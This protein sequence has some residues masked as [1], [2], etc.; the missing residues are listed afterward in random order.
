PDPQKWPT[1]HGALPDNGSAEALRAALCQETL[2]FVRAGLAARGCLICCL[3]GRSRSVSVLLGFLLLERGVGV[4]EG[5]DLVRSSRP[6]EDTPDPAPTRA[7]STIASSTPRRR[8][9]GDVG[10]VLCLRRLQREAAGALPAPAAAAGAGSSPRAGR[11]AVA[12]TP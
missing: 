7:Q 12:A 1:D 2:D 6:Q 9:S 11:A 4:D 10:F 8:R 3:Q 5:L